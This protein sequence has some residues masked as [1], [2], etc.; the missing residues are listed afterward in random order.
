MDGGIDLETVSVARKAG[1]TV[2]VAGSAI[3]HSGDVP[4]TIARFLEL[5]SAED[6]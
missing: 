5:L 1:A 4:G 2:F 6:G 3:F